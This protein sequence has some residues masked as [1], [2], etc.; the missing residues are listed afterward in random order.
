LSAPSF[1]F[2]LSLLRITVFSANSVYSSFFLTN[3]TLPKLPDPSSFTTSKSYI[4][5]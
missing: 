5:I 4:D 1:S 2:W 3:L